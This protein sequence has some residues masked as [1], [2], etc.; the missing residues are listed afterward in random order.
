MLDWDDLRIFLAVAR[1]GSFVA[2]GR[3][4][5]LNHTTLARRMTALE[6][7]YGTRLLNRSPRGVQPT[8]AGLDLIEHAE[9]VE[10]EVLAAGRRIE[11]QDGDISGVVRLATPEAFGTYFIASRAHHLHA[12]H[13]RI[14]LELA[15]ESRAVNL[16][17]READIAIS[18]HR[19]DQGRLRSVRLVDYRIGLFAS[20]ALLARVGPVESPTALR[21]LPFISYIEE[22]ID[23][24]ELRNLDRSVANRCV[25]RS[26]SVAAQMEAVASG[27]GFG[28][29]HCFAV[30]PHMRLVRVLP[31]AVDIVRSYW[32]VLHHDLARVPRIRAVADFVAEQVRTEKAAF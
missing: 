17:K 19:P 25:F 22:M 9:R 32:M 31:E 16:S 18:L 7:S 23:L 4:L 20:E 1:S 3:R 6:S 27:L 30:R 26:S 24:P 15:P 21:E 5:G 29:L 10:E 2:S 8:K 28:M 14:E 13:P 11:G 12:R